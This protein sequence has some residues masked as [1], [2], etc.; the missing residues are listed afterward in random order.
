MSYFRLEKLFPSVDERSGADR[1]QGQRTPSV[2]VAAAFPRV[3]KPAPLRAA[4]VAFA[5]ATQRYH[6]EGK[7][8]KTKIGSRADWLTARR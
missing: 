4:V 6:A 3:V 2:A 7:S 5:G 1:N 8:A